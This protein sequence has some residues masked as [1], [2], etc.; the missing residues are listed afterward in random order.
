MAG[1]FWKSSL[2][3][4]LNLILLSELSG[5]VH[6]IAADYSASP[7]E[8]GQG[9]LETYLCGHYSIGDNICWVKDGDL[10]GLKLQI[11]TYFSGDVTLVSDE[12]DVHAK[13]SFLDSELLEF[14]LSKLI[15]NMPKKM[16]L[17]DVVMNYRFP[18]QERSAV[19]VHG[20]TGRLI[21]GSLDEG[22][23]VAKI[24]SHRNIF[25]E[26]D[27]TYY[28]GAVILSI[29]QNQMLDLL[30]TPFISLGGSSKGAY[31]VSGCGIEQPIQDYYDTEDEY[32]E[33]FLTDI[34]IQL[35]EGSHCVLYGRVVRPDKKTDL[36]FLVGVEIMSRYLVQMAMPILEY[37]D[38]LSIRTNEP[39]SWT[40]V[41][42]R[43]FNMASGRVSIE[44]AKLTILR[45]I[46]AKGRSIVLKIIDS[47]IVW[48]K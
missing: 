37:G 28:D 27:D 6:H 16:C 38:K 24:T 20:M 41:N 17:I 19:M 40:L 29:Y 18:D 48:S 15:K 3:L 35:P 14:P 11:Q 42:D 43:A 9:R 32:L 2:N 39:V 22:M 44:P 7:I 5:C 45:Q 26:N 30:F 8:E 21:L 4:I 10:A 33:I 23:E 46:T 13:F 47:E 12:C 34:L 25:F 1:S 31:M 36:V